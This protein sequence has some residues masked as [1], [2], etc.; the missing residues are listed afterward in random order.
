MPAFFSEPD[1]ATRT[2]V[3]IAPGSPFSFERR[4]AVDVRSQ[5]RRRSWGGSRDRSGGGE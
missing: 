2:R 4:R 3:R 1:P 5:L